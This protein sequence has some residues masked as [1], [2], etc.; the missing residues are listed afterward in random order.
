MASSGSDFIDI[1]VCFLDLLGLFAVMSGLAFY[2]PSLGV[3]YPRFFFMPVILPV[4]DWVVILC[5]AKF[6]CAARPTACSIDH[7]FASCEPIGKK[8]AG[9]Q[10]IQGYSFDR[11]RH[12]EAL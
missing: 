7:V 5:T 2:A 11:L 8:C 3:I 10:R 12:A 6:V 9:M 4:S 1:F